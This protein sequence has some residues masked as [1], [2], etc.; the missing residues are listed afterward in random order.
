MCIGFSALVRI[1][2]GKTCTNRRDHSQ[3]AETY[4][5]KWSARSV[6]DLICPM[7]ANISTASRK[8]DDLP[9]SF[10]SCSSISPLPSQLGRKRLRRFGLAGT[11]KQRPFLFGLHSR[12]AQ[13]AEPNTKY[14]NKK[15][16][17]Q[18]TPKKKKKDK[19]FSHGSWLW[20][21]L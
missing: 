19:N 5:C 13:P 11:R 8:T 1:T 7:W 4:P 6:N 2:S 10:P 14:R 15:Q 17:H 12:R 18:D 21:V 9:E 20:S 16:N 3:I